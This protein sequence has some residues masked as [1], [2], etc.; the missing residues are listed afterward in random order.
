MPCALMFS[1]ED[2]LRCPFIGSRGFP[3]PRRPRARDLLRQDHA[4]RADEAGLRH[5]ADTDD[6]EARGLRSDLSGE[7]LHDIERAGG[8]A[9]RH[10]A[11][12]RDD[13]QARKRFPHEVI[14]GRGKDPAMAEAD[15][16]MPAAA[17]GFLEIGGCRTDDADQ[18]LRAGAG[19]QPL[20]LGRRDAQA[21][22]DLGLCQ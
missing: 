10:A 5:A 19:D 15:D 3:P 2:R 16:P 11:E 18:P 7:G 4:A 12:H 17:E 20:Y 8:D 13:G 21:L 1:L 22:T 9:P 6:E 14:N